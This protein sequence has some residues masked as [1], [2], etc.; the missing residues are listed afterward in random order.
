MK[1]E[2]GN[3][4]FTEIEQDGTMIDYVDH[5]FVAVIKDEKWSDVELKQF[6]N[7]KLQVDVVYQKDLLFFLLTVNNAIETSDFIFNV[8]EDEYNMDEFKTF[9]NGEG[10]LFHL[11]LLDHANIVCASKKVVLSTAMSN[12]VSE[13]LHKQ[14]SEQFDEAVMDQCL[15]DLQSKYEPFEMQEM[16]LCTQKY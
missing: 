4:F 13:L 2:T 8:N 12:C 3:K 10:Y 14:K 5:T 6:K 9:K 16:A 7:N 11:Y 1:I 15:A